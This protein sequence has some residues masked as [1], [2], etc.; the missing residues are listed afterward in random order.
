MKSFKQYFNE[1][2]TVKDML[3][4]PLEK[5][6]ANVIFDLGRERGSTIPN[7]WLQPDGRFVGNPKSDEPIEIKIKS[8]KLLSRTSE[9]GAF[10]RQ[11]VSVKYE[12]KGE[13]KKGLGW[14]S[15]SNHPD[16]PSIKEVVAWI[17]KK[18]K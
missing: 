2:V 3:S 1:A 8:M 13:E 15:V 11:S 18:G 6:V 10:N 17:N 12:L 9:F 7:Y 14:I 16:M 4:P 5:R